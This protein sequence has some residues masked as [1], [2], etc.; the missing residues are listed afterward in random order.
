MNYIIDLLCI[1]LLAIIISQDF[2]QRK[3]SWVLLPL[4]FFLFGIN[5]I[6]E[7]GLEATWS[8][9]LYNTIFLILQ[10]T[11][12]T[13]YFS[14][15]KRKFINI[16]NTYMGIGDILFLLIVCVAF[17]PISFIYFYLCSLLMTLVV[18][19]FYQ[20]FYKTVSNEI[21]LAGGLALSLIFCLVSKYLNMT[22]FYFLLNIF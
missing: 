4:L 15:R 22:N 6:A 9:F 21:P 20:K 17:S 14:F 7:N 2:L 8:A 3:I 19:F 10:L 1:F 16:I 18:F 13:I 11:M 5:T 12:L